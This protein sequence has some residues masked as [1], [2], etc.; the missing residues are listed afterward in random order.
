VT[1]TGRRRRTSDPVRRSRLC[2]KRRASSGVRDGVIQLGTGGLLVAHYIDEPTWVFGTSKA[3]WQPITSAGVGRP[4]PLTDGGLVQGNIWIFKDLMAA[5][6]Q[7]RRPLGSASDGRAALEMILAV[8]ESH[9]QRGPV[10]LPLKNR[11]H[12][13]ARL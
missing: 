11:D 6:E 3:K 9:R 5:I 1:T 10:E 7:D 12:P 13:L 4:E 8:Y 2:G